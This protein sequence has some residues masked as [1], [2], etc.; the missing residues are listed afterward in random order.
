MYA[1]NFADA[2]CFDRDIPAESFA[3]YAGNAFCRSARR[4]ELVDVVDFPDGRLITVALEHLAGPAQ[5]REE[6]N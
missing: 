2:L 3:D 6:D 1:R 4:V 5:G